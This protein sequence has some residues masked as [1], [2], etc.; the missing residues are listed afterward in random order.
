MDPNFGQG[1]ALLGQGSTDAIQ[2]AMARRQTGQAGVT[3]QASPMSAGGGQPMPQA[4]TGQSPMG[5]PAPQGG[6]APM[7]PQGATAAPTAPQPQALPD[8][9]AMEN[10]IILKALVQKM[11][12]NA[13]IAESQLIPSTPP[14]GQ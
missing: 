6:S 1:A 4:P 9:H 7:P 12:S 2:Q 5:M 13:D 14:S 8:I 10:Q 3:S 11:K